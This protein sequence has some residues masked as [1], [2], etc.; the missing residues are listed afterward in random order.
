MQQVTA[1]KP[2]GV[3]VTPPP[4]SAPKPSSP[5]Q[6]IE[7]NPY[8]DTELTNMRLTIAHRLLESKT[9]IP[10]YYLT[11]NINMNNLIK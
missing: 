10:H 4:T 3:K 2:E 5:V 6:A 7:G 1:K 11:M 9:T 8:V